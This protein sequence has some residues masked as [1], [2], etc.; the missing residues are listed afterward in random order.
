MNQKNVKLDRLDGS[1]TNFNRW[2]D[3]LMFFLTALKVAYVLSPDLPEIP[4][5]TEGESDD[6]RKLRV[7]REEDE[8]LC[9]GHILNNVSDAIYDLFINERSP[10]QIWT[11]IEREYATQKQSADKFLIK[12]ILSLNCCT[13]LLLWIKFI[14]FKLLCPS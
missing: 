4:P 1:S 8:V 14:I 7:K 12:S 3:K 6:V 5:P 9:R 10:R 11:T 2:K 13:I